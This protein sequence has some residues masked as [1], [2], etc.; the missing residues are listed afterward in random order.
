[1]ARAGYSDNFNARGY[2]YLAL[3][4]GTPGNLFCTTRN[5][6]DLL[7]LNCLL[8]HIFHKKVTQNQCMQ[9]NVKDSNDQPQ[10]LA[11]IITVE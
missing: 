2:I 1:M 3:R 5:P 9:G 7:S 6:N 11:L 4:K 8:E 10:N